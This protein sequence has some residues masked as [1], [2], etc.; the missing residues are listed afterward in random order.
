MFWDDRPFRWD[1]AKPLYIGEYLWMPSRDP[2][3]QTIFFGDEA[4][5]DH[6][7]YQT[8]AKALAWR[9]QILAYRHYGV[10]GH[11]PWTV[12]E[13]GA[14]DESNPL[15]LHHG[16]WWIQ[17]DMMTRVFGAIDDLATYVRA[18]Q[19]LQAE[20]MRY[21]YESHRRRKW[22]CGGTMPWQFNESWPNL[23][24]TNSFDYYGHPRPAFWWAKLAYEP[25]HVSAKYDKLGWEPGETLYSEV[26]LNNSLAEEKGCEVTW[27]FTDL[28]GA[29]LASGEASAD[30]PGGSATKVTDIAFE[31]PEVDGGVFIVT[32]RASA[33]SG[34]A[35]TNWYLFACSGEPVYAPLLSAPRTELEVERD[36]GRLTL[37]NVGPVWALCVQ[38][39][40]ADGETWITPSTNYIMLAPGEELNITVEPADVPVEVSGLNFAPA[41]V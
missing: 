41:V 9:M 16:S 32:V 38:V 3:P 28:A 10:S 34:A 11:S 29:V 22:H 31:V 40:P 17:R 37:R 15:W 30:A 4:Y 1:R 20:A 13:H 35:S 33:P 12:Q 7:K 25:F 39:E 27:Q 23:S 18:S 26:W 5:R 2:A 8:L 21:G 24:C 19:L 14:L 6:Q 36:G